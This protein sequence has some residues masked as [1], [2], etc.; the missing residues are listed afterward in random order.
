[1]TRTI[2]IFLFLLT[3]LL[4][5]GQK[6]TRVKQPFD[7]EKYAR[8]I[9]ETTLADTTKQLRYQGIQLIKD[10]VDLIKFAEP[11][12]FKHYS[13]ETIK[14]EKPYKMFLFD[15]YWVMYG[16]LH[17]TMGGTFILV[18]DSRDCQILRLIH[19]K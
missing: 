12:L 14:S 1:L 11:I 4:S 18:V 2:F 9:L 13:E 5:H 10:T 7:E 3:S 17:Y 19:E 6:K 15:K 16:T 8:R